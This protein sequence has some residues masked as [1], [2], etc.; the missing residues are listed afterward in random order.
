M[1]HARNTDPETSHEAAAAI[2]PADRSE[3][4]RAIIALLATPRTD[5]ELVNAYRTYVQLGDY[6][7]RT[8]QRIRTARAEITEPDGPV[9]DTGERRKSETGHAMT[10]WQVKK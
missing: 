7:A 8:P 9:R 2:T 4:Q 5:E 10:V 3:L 1:K 6:P